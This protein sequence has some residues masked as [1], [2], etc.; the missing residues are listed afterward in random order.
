MK[1]GLNSQDADVRQYH[2]GVWRGGLNDKR[3]R[4]KRTEV[5][6]RIL[7]P[8]LAPTYKHEQP[9]QTIVSTVREV[10][11]EV[12]KIPP[13]FKDMKPVF[14]L[15][16]KAQQQPTPEPEAKEDSRQYRVQFIEKFCNER[17]GKND[18]EGVGLITSFILYIGSENFKEL[19]AFLNGPNRG[20][21]S[22]EDR[23][24]YL[25]QVEKTAYIEIWNLPKGDDNA[26]VI[27]QIKFSLIE[28]EQDRAETFEGL[29]IT[30]RG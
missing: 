17:K 23:H 30:T 18:A 13:I 9:V 11:K 12:A 26:R 8:Y 15:Q 5:L 25:M 27:K 16:P 4:E 14:P 19:N 22:L 6:V 29:L 2:S 7:K 28:V 1:D 24:L 21:V 3:N 20:H 10:V